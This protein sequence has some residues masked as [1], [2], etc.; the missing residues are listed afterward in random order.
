VGD[1][2][3][4]SHLVSADSCLAVNCSSPSHA[5]DCEQDRRD[6]FRCGQPQY[7]YYQMNLT[8]SVNFIEIGNKEAA[9]S[10][11]GC[12]AKVQIIPAFTN[13]PLMTSRPSDTV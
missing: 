9:A 8:L 7:F 5:T 2:P 13:V 3:L 1:V 6:S 10:V 4:L 11:L 12:A